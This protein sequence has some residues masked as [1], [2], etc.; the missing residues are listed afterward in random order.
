MCAHCDEL[1]DAIRKFGE[2]IGQASKGA[3]ANAKDMAEARTVEALTLA[4]I[5]VGRAEGFQGALA[6]M[7]EEIQAVNAELRFNMAQRT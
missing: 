3:L 2:R 6:V 4:S 5:Q 1:S 7:A